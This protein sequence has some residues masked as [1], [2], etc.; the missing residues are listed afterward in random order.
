MAKVSVV[1]AGGISGKPL[2]LTV[3]TVLEAPLLEQFRGGMGRLQRDPCA[4]EREAWRTGKI[5]DPFT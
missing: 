3:E 1:P 4:L 2:R 5:D